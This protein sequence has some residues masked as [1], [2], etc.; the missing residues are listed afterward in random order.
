MRNGVGL[1]MRLTYLSKFGKQLPAG[2]DF[3]F[4]PLWQLSDLE[5]GTLNSQ[6]TTSVTDAV[7]K[8]LVGK[9]TG[10]MEL[11]QSGRVT[12]YW[13]NITQDAID[14]ASD[15]PDEGGS[16]FDPMGAPIV[17]DEGDTDGGSGAPGAGQPG[18]K[19]KQGLAVAA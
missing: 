12:G 5:K 2:S 17:G 6:V 1:L 3:V 11:K 13:S 15:D 14:A 8:G 18:G 19:A 7:T 16:E 10:L 4:R 9:K